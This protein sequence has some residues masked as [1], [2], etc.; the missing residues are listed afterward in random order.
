MESRQLKSDPNIDRGEKIIAPGVILYTVDVREGRYRLNDTSG[1]FGLDETIFIRSFDSWK[2]MVH[3]KDRKRFES[4][5]R[6]RLKHRH[7]NAETAYHIRT[8]PGTYRFVLDRSRIVDSDSTG[9]PITV[10]G[11]LIDITDIRK[12]EEKL[13]KQY[14]KW[15]SALARS[16]AEKS[17]ILE[18]LSGLVSIRLLDPEMRI[19]WSN[20]DEPFGTRQQEEKEEGHFCY[21]IIRGRTDPCDLLCTTKMAFSS[22][23]LKKTE[24]IVDDGR[25]FIIG[26]NPVK[27]PSGNIF[28][29]VYFRLNVTQHKKMEERYH[30]TYKF[31]HSFLRTL[32][33]ADYGV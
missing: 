23:E 32:P 4:E 15:E 31:L 33:H 26:A 12:K 24:T 10:C 9:D 17:A 22:G 20:M 6:S 8:E 30:V 21:Q 27:D 5:Y 25:S 11:S 1:L 19:V 13:E 2:S 3:P 14:R 7:L 28:G 16:E 29:V 18:A